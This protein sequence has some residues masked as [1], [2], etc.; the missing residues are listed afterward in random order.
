MNKIKAGIYQAASIHLDKVGSMTKL[1]MMNNINKVMF[2]AIVIFFSLLI[3][4]PLDRTETVFPQ[5]LII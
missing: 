1:M 4:A 2:R 5:Y 3:I